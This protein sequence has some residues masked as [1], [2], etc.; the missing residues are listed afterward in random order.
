MKRVDVPLQELPKVRC[1]AGF[2]QGLDFCTAIKMVHGELLAYYGA[3]IS[4]ISQKSL[5]S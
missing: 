5:L 2:D 4:E 1:S 3:D